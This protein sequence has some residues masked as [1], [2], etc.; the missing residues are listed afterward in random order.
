MT[1]LELFYFQHIMR[2]QGFGGGTVR[3]ETSESQQEERSTIYEMDQL[4]KNQCA[5]HSS[6]AGLLRVGHCGHHTF[7][8]LPRVGV[9]SAACDTYCCRHRNIRWQQCLSIAAADLVCNFSSTCSIRLPVPS[10]RDTCIGCLMSPPHRS[11][12]LLWAQ[13]CQHHCLAPPLQNAAVRSTVC[14]TTDKA[15]HY[16]VNF[17]SGSHFFLLSCSCSGTDMVSVCCWWVWAGNK[18]SWKRL[19]CPSF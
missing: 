12:F 16:L 1:K 19:V 13:R 6:C 15:F 9:H 5:H 18:H 10:L 7:I 4:R 8:G 2:R 14:L 11:E 17:I 3:L